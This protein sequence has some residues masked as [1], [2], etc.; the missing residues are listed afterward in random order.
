MEEGYEGF[1][2]RK[3]CG[4]SIRNSTHAAISGVGFRRKY[5]QLMMRHKR[6]ERDLVRKDLWWAR[7]LTRTQELTLSL[8]RGMSLL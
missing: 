7:W 8:L 1:E 6:I 4:L 3:G 5:K 2:G